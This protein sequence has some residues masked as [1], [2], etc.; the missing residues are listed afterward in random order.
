MR[1]RDAA[2]WL[3]RQ[4]TDRNRQQLLRQLRRDSQFPVAILFYHRVAVSDIDNPW[5]ISAGDFRRHLDW[6]QTNCDIVSLC[7]AQ[8]RIRSPH[9]QRLAVAI[10]F[11]DG[12]SD[13]ARYAIPELVA[14][15]LPATYFVATDFVGAHVPF[16]HDADLGKPLAANSLDELQEFARQGIELGAHTR[17]HVD[18]GNV[19]D[20]QILKHEIAGSVEALNHWLGHPCRYFAFPYGQPRNMTQQAVNLIRQ[21]RLAGFCSAYGAFNWPGHEGYHLRRIHADP[22]LERLKNWLTLDSRKLLDRTVL[23][24]VDQTPALPHCLADFT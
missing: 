24:F 23:P 5:S 14:R 22:G 9:N 15:G 3:Y 13:N 21:L 17:S 8:Q 18:L 2:I 7:A 4:M 20:A 11:D 12:Y 16:P 10:T 6:L 19:T 1:I